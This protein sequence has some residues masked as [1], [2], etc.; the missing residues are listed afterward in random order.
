MVTLEGAPT[1]GTVDTT[2]A[3]SG[4]YIH[5]MFASCNNHPLR[6]LL[7]NRSGIL[8]K[9]GSS[10]GDCAHHHWSIIGTCVSGIMV[11]C[12]SLFQVSANEFKFA[13]RIFD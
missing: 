3:G 2:L 13:C 1:T 9:A 4:K 6:R 12:L 5:R 8:V 7:P 10:A 11:R